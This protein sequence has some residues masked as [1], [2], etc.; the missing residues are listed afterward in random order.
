MKKRYL[1]LW[2]L[3]VVLS[4]LL[5][6]SL[7]AFAT[8]DTTQPP[9]EPGPSGSVDSSGPAVEPDP[10]GSS[11]PVEPPA[12]QDTTPPVITHTVIANGKL[13]AELKFEATATDDVA[14]AEVRLLYRIPGTE[15]WTQALMT[16][17][18]CGIYSAVLAAESVTMDTLEYYI[19]ASDGTNVA[20]TAPAVI[21]MD[22]GISVTSLSSDKANL[23]DL[24][25]PITV[26][27]EGFAEG[28]VITVG[29]VE[30]AYTLVS[31]TELQLTLPVLPLGKQDLVLTNGENTCTRLAAI[32]YEDPASFVK[33]SA[34]EKV[35]IGQKIG[36]PISI[37]SSASI[38]ELSVQIQLDPTYFQNIEFMLGTS[39]ADAAAS[40][41][42]NAQGLVTI[43]LSSLTPL[44]TAEP[45]GYITANI[46]F[47]EKNVTTFITV[48]QAKFHGVDVKAFECPVTVSNEISIALLNLPETVYALE[49]MVPE[50]ADW[51]LEIDYEGPKAT[52]PI[53]ADMI[54]LIPESPGQ[55]K[56]TYFHKEILVNFTVL[57]KALTTVTIKTL[58]TKLHYIIGE[59]LDLTGMELEL[60]YNEGQLVL[61]LHNYTVSGFDS[62]VQGEQTVTITYGEFTNTFQITVFLKGDINCDGKIS[63]LDMVSIK[64]HVLGVSELTDLAALAADYNGD[65]KISILDYV[66]I[67]AFIL[68]ITTGE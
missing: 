53:T 62:Q 5:A 64:S 33:V 29:G 19:E 21:L 9:D 59:S 56:V 10:S 58:P 3:I 25:G 50:F 36:L 4:L 63:I 14:V 66:Q 43:T 40:C 39:N 1:Q 41:M 52:I 35:Y 34:S 27:G 28:M 45:I 6:F 47:V 38:T 61:P 12:P 42:V 15:E 7:S 2:S 13:G 18:E 51:L 31:D 17:N 54:S 46:P 44:T 30:A 22:K 26:L 8:E 37:G 67:K 60:S 55:A 23:T 49:G 32:T 16:C 65:G 57:E 68:G 48:P 24:S 20:A 11:E